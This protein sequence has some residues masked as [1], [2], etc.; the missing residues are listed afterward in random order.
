MLTKGY[1]KV[2]CLL[3]DKSYTLNDYAIFVG[4]YVCFVI[5]DAVYLQNVFVNAQH[6]PAGMFHL[7]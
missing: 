2:E 3:R 1:G 4:L 5:K 7:F 6:F